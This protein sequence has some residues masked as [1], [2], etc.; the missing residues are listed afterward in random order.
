MHLSVVVVFLQKA[1]P[2]FVAEYLIECLL[3]FESLAVLLSIWIEFKFI[4]SPIVFPP[5]KE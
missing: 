2:L 1:K 4:C 3:T 5:L